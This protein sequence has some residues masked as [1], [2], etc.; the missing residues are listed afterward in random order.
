MC[1]RAALDGGN[2]RHR[3]FRHLRSANIRQLTALAAA[4]G[5]PG[6]DMLTWREGAADNFHPE[7]V[8]RPR[9]D[10]G[11]IPA[12]LRLAD[13]RCAASRAYGQIPRREHPRGKPGFLAHED[14]IPRE[15]TRW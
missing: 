14:K 10:V 1:R 8:S 11:A 4:A 2:G 15:I 3:Q 13:G 12:P 5:Q 6:T 7:R 9:V